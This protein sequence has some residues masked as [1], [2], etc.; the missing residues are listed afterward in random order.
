MQ[1]KLLATVSL[2]ALS[3]GACQTTGTDNISVTEKTAPPVSETSVAMY[4]YRAQAN[5]EQVAKIPEWYLTPP[6]KEGSIYAVGSA[7]TPDLQLSVD[8]AILQAKTTLA[9]RWQSTLKSQTKNFIAKVGSSAF[10]SSVINEVERVTK[11]LV[12]GT[13]VSGYHMVQNEVHSSGPMFRSFVLLEYNDEQ[14]AKILYN[15]MSKDRM[16]MNKLRSN[17]AFQELEGAVDKQRKQ[18]QSDAD[19]KIKAF[20]NPSNS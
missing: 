6:H 7:S 16:L 12:A 4:K 13:D 8:L 1:K 14:A 5:K 11:N 9:D 19:A 15:R 17:K 3:L 18:E 2:V 20:V 10:D